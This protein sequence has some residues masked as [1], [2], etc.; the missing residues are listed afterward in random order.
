MASE[1]QHEATHAA[2]DL[3]VAPAAQPAVE[4]PG[5]KHLRELF[6]KGTPKPKEVVAVLDAHRGEREAILAFLHAHAGNEYVA[7]VMAEVDKLRLHLDRKELVAGDPSDPQSGYF[8]ASQKEAGARWRTA[9]GD[10]TGK[11]DKAGLDARYKLG[12]ETALHLG[13][14]AKQ[15]EGALGLERGGEV[16]GELA[17][18]Y[19]G[20]DDWSAGLRRPFELDG[21]GVITPQLRHQ[22]RPEVGAADVAAVGYRDGGTTADAYVGRSE[23]GGLAAGLSGEYKTDRGAIAGAYD[24]TPETD[25]LAVT[26]NYRFDDRTAMS[27]ALSHIGRQNGDDIT[28]LSLSGTHRLDDRTTLSGTLS[29]T[30][31]RHGEDVTALALSERYRSPGLVHGLDLSYS[32]GDK[33]RVHMG[34]FADAQLGKGLYGGVWGGYDAATGDRPTT[35][36]GASLTFTPHEKAALTLAGVI[37]ERGN[38][39]T[40]LELD[41]FKSKIENV[42]GLSDNKKNA[43]VSLFLSYS[44]GSRRDLF[45][46][47][48]GAPTFRHDSPLGGGNDAMIG[49]GI[50]IRF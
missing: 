2:A 13:V 45:D 34:G 24:H 40:R 29:H 8:I 17:G 44:Q 4:G 28:A 7:N 22:V 47:R 5:V 20:K 43:L 30:E 36:L 1:R 12:E 26:G 37:D 49:A 14:D 27:G 35:T 16:V 9:D 33:D 50:R 18:R 31:R 32:H 42:Q 6:A 38:F 11:V 46:D 15:K 41:V 3:D 23:S 39:E 19:K 25:R 10:F 48:Y 21:G